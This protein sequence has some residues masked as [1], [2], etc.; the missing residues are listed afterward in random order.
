MYLYLRI[1]GFEQSVFQQ[2]FDTKSPIITQLSI[3]D[4][5]EILT[6]RSLYS[7]YRYIGVLIYT[8]FGACLVCMHAHSAGIS[9]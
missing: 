6:A 1:Q 8:V 7:K 3:L 4:L 9:S 5:V 2:I